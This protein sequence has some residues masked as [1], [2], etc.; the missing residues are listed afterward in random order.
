MDVTRRMT[1]DPETLGPKRTVAEARALMDAGGY[2]R[3]PIVDNG[4]LVGIIS[5]RDVRRHRDAL[6]TPIENAMTRDPVTVTVASSVEQAARLMLKHK[7][8]GLP[9]ME[10][11]KLVGILT[12]TDVLK[13]FLDVIQASQTLM[14]P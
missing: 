3:M 7:I 8:G 9:V 1:R 13:A 5:D 10:H 6:S 2:R 14:N 12:T 4:R 11:D